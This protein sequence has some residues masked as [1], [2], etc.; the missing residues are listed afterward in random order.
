MGVCIAD[1]TLTHTRG[2]GAKAHCNQTVICIP[3][4]A[5]PTFGT[6]KGPR[7]RWVLKW[8]ETCSH[9]RAAQQPSKYQLFEKHLVSG[10]HSASGLLHQFGAGEA[11]G[12]QRG[13]LARALPPTEPDSLL[14]DCRSPRPVYKPHA[15]RLAF[16]LF[17]LAPLSLLF[18]SNASFRG[19]P[20]RW[21]AAMADDERPWP[22]GH[23]GGGSGGV[24]VGGGGGGVGGGEGGG[25]DASGPFVPAPS[26]P[27]A[28]GDTAFS[29]H[30][31]ERI[32][33]MLDHRLTK[34]DC[35]QRAG[36]G[37][38]KLTYLE[39]WKVIDL[40]NKIFGWDGWSCESTLFLWVAV[41]GG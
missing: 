39:S 1:C 21:A 30:D 15:F 12:A 23:G 25:S 16:L 2:P 19:D 27:A 34:S 33:R 36:P 35:K 5:E 18:L 37:G 13:G 11:F 32:G 31:A 22:G 24:G 26:L 4:H 14:H 29:R 28:F 41:Q 40:A 7:V 38:R 6:P 20:L 17:R 10:A 9:G 8:P 3:P